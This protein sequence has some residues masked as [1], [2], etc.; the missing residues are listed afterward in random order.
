MAAC[1]SCLTALREALPEAQ[2]VSV[3]E[4]LDGLPLEAPAAGNSLP[5]VFSIQ[6][7]CTA[8]HDAAWLAAVRS[9]ADKCG[10]K[11]EEP[12]L[13]GASTACCGYGGLVWCAQPET[14]RA[15]TLRR[16]QS[17]CPVCLRRVEATYER[18]VKDALTVV[19]RKTCPDHGT[20]SVPVWREAKP[21]AVATPP[22]AA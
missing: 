8:R 16:T 2:T 5:S 19:L 1:S 15:M 9:L 20:F 13:S 3:W 21:G 12:R 11:I 10:A 17:L 18:S 6:D 22:F 4:V 14:A 7:P